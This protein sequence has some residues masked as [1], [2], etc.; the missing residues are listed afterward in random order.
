MKHKRYLRSASLALLVVLGAT[1]AAA[2]AAGPTP[3]EEL[4]QCLAVPEQEQ[5]GTTNYDNFV[6]GR[7]NRCVIDDRLLGVSAG[8]V[9]CGWYCSESCCSF[10]V[11]T[12]LIWMLP[13]VSCCLAPPS[14]FKTSILA[15]PKLNSC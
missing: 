8:T 6:K 11:C 9:W 5:R 4:K 2:V 15:K 13:Y 3:A 12:A 10:F 7:P 1:A 14:A